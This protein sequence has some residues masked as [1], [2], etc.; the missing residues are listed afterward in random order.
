MYI[1]VTEDTLTIEEEH[2]G[3][4]WLYVIGVVF[5]LMGFGPGVVLAVREQSI[6]PLFIGGCM[7]L[8]VFGLPFFGVMA[9]SS[10][11]HVV[12]DVRT[13]AVVASRVFRLAGARVS[14]FAAENVR[15]VRCV[16]YHNPEGA[17]ALRVS[18]VTSDEQQWPILTRGTWSDEV[19]S[20]LLAVYGTRVA[21]R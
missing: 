17:D 18:V 13:G 11:R 19:V 21:V 1:S 6:T 4:R 5:V 20:R 14:R 15:E 3:R 16:R 2:I 9:L 7:G 12:I 10:Y 8:F